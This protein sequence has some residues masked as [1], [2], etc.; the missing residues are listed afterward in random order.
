MNT[1]IKRNNLFPAFGNFFDDFFTKDLFNWNDK[2]FAGSGATL[3]SV[4]VKE[5][6]NEFAIE[7]AAPGMKKEDFKIELNN[8]VLTI[9]SEQKEEHEEKD[10]AG[11]YT[12]REFNY[13]SFSRSFTL[14]AETVESEKIEAAYKD[15]ILNIS[16]PK[17]ETA[18]PQPVKT[19]AIQ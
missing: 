3:P 17:K 18:K 4:N 11:K 6:D 15:G 2:N 8:H 5:N 1:I 7:L 12:R 9:S 13:R 16:I 10:K 14:P 19:I